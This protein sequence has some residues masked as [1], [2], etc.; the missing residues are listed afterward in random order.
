[1][2]AQLA[3]NMEPSFPMQELE[4]LEELIQTS[5]KW[6]ENLEDRRATL[7]AQ[8]EKITRPQPASPVAVAKTIRRGLEYR[9]VVS[10]HWYYIDIHVDLLQKLWTEFPNQRDAMAQAIGCRGRT[11]TYVAKTTAALFP[12]KP[13]E[14]TQKH[15]RKL[16]DDWY[17]DT[18][19][20]PNQ[21]RPIL[22]AAIAA[23]GLK[24][25]EDVKIFWRRTQIKS[26]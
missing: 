14:F 11:R 18:N 13:L 2:H 21:M 8:L 10:V 15:S 24:F 5:R 25:G 1:M 17:V 23:A 12:G 9:G 22:Y 16:V 3:Q 26:N 20:N 4:Q 7:S 6:F 19:L